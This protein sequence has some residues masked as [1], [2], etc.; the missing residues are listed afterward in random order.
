MSNGGRRRATTRQDAADLVR[1]LEVDMVVI[2]RD[3]L[4][5][6]RTADQG[7]ARGQARRDSSRARRVYEQVTGRISSRR[8]A[9]R[10]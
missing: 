1:K 5:Y 9:R 3:H 8:C 7:P 10:T 4:N 2:A 6:R